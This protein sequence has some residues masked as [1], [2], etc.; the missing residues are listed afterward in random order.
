VILSVAHAA[1]FE[2][3]SVRDGSATRQP[4][5][6]VGQ[7]TIDFSVDG[8]RN[9]MRELLVKLHNDDGARIRANAVRLGNDM[10]KGWQKGGEASRE[11]ERFL[12]RFV[13][14]V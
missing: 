6:F 1:G 2:L 4:L 9:E 12:G 5:R 7:D 14:G 13:D 10:S 11:V 8:V 3:V